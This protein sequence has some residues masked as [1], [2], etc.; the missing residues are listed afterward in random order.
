MKRGPKPKP[1]ALKLAEGNPGKRI[2]KLC[3]EAAAGP[4]EPVSKLTGFALKEFNRILVEAP[5]I[6]AAHA[7]ALTDRCL[8]VQRLLEAE[9]DISRRG[10]VLENGKDMNPMLRAVRLYRTALQRY[11]SEL[12]LTPSSQERI[13]SEAQ[14]T[15]FDV[16][17][18]AGPKKIDS[19]E[20]KL[21]G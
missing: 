4:F 11:D 8:C 15:L 14:G 16:P 10:M 13:S 21:C 12:G 3:V 6:K 1:F 17:S 7:K 5:W 2:P 18:S 9:Q 19:I 20:S